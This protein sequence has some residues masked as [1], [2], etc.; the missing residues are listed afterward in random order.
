MIIETFELPS[1]WATALLYGELDGFEDEDVQAIEGF[2]RYMHV[3][4]G[5]CFCVE[6][7][8]DTDFKRWHDACQFGVLA[9]GVSTF[10][11][12]VTPEE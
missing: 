3:N 9:S 6:V 5:S 2:E 11:F 1:H 12:D 4:F 8:D 7:S 10:T